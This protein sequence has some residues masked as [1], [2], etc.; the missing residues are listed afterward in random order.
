MWTD[1]GGAFFG[2]FPQTLERYGIVHKTTQPYNPQQNGKIERWWP[3]TDKYRADELG[4]VV[5]WYNLH[6]PHSALMPGPRADSKSLRQTPM[7]AF[8][9]LPRSGPGHGGSWQVDGESRP[10]A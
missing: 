8:R 10:F 9:S 3:F 4:R 6:Q 1:N 7:E 2:E 5:Q